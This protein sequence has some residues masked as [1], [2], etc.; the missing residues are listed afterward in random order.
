MPPFVR[1]ERNVGWWLR[2]RYGVENVAKQVHI[3]LFDAAGGES[4]KVIVDYIALGP[5]TGQLHF[6]DAKTTQDASKYRQRMGYESLSTRGGR[7][8]SAQEKL[9]GWLTT[10]Q[11]LEPVGKVE[12]ITEEHHDLAK[13]KREIRG[14]TARTSASQSTSATPKLKPEVEVPS[15]D[16]STRSSRLAGRAEKLSR[17]KLSFRGNLVVDL[18]KLVLFSVLEGKLNRVNQERMA[19]DYHE[20]IYKRFVDKHVTQELARTHSRAWRRRMRGAWFYVTVYYAVDM[21]I[22]AEGGQDALVAIA[23][24]FEFVQV[25][26]RTYTLSRPPSIASET[27]RREVDLLV[28]YRKPE[29]TRSKN[30][31]RYHYKARMPIWEENAYREAQN[32]RVLREQAKKRSSM[33]KDSARRD[34]VRAKLDGWQ[35]SAAFQ[36]LGGTRGLVMRPHLRFLVQTILAGVKAVDRANNFTH[37]QKTIVKL[38][39]DTDPFPKRRVAPSSEEHL[40]ATPR[41][42]YLY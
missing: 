20:F 41:R 9:P 27:T 17:L 35:F 19:I 30:V 29:K 18:A 31:L 26:Q 28:Q 5:E 6:F 42:G 23:R 21:E 24:G 2:K 15:A 22:Q 8:V 13:I 25:Y 10:G 34:R 14:T 16:V 32:L 36:E 39:L 11:P 38:L 7:V 33:V 4:G 40:S 12:H 1:H 37:Q 3:R